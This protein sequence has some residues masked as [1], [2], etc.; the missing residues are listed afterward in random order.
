MAAA[1]PSR[2]LCVLVEVGLL[3][4]RTGCRS[5]ADVTAVA[6]EV[7]K[8][9]RLALVGVSGYEGPLGHGR[10]DDTL[11]RVAHYVRRLADTLVRLDGDGLLDARAEEFIVSCGGSGQV[12]VVTAA[13]AAPFACSR[14]VRP[15][16][17]SGAYVTFD[18]GLYARTSS[19]AEELRPAIELWCQVLSRP[20]PSLAL[21][22]AGRRDVSFDSGLPIPLWRRAAAT[23]NITALRG[24]ITAL[25]D[26]H[27]Y[28]EIEKTAGLEKSAD[29]EIGD[30][31]CLGISHSCTT[32]DKW[33][34]IPLLDDDRRVLDCIRCY[35]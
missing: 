25:N 8:H 24:T 26:Q 21:L 6:R 19:L 17:R 5:D 22:G 32:H 34:L 29:L 4:G 30:L 14:P 23:G 3:G 11:D 18:H 20:E 33:Q 10:D 12:D 15:I 2:P 28:L 1:P 27:G 31:V 35:F 13:L 7:A 16:L 9:D